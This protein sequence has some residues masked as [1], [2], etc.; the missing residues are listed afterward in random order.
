[1]D[2]KKIIDSIKKYGSD[3]RD[4]CLFG[5]GVPPEQ[6]NQH[7]IIAPWWEPSMLPLLGEAEY[8]SA[9]E[10]AEIKV[11]NIK[12]K[13]ED[14]TAEALASDI[15]FIKTGIGAPVLMD[16]ILAL[17]VT[18]CKSAI[19]VGAVGALDESMCIG[20]IVIPE[21]SLCGDGASRYI[22]SDSL[23]GG[24]IFGQAAY[25][26]EKLYAQLL[27]N[28]RIL[29]EENGVALHIGRTYSTDT[30][31]AEYAHI[32][33]IKDMGCN[34]I[35][36]ETAA[37]FRAARMAGFSLAAAFSISDNTFTN[38]TLY[39]K[40]PEEETAYRRFAR[41]T[42]F[43]QIIRRTLQGLKDTDL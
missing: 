38:Q 6:I 39:K 25:P 30:I 8:I 32:D 18:P 16:V 33:E 43:P 20:D 24:D 14:G 34:V 15:T 13:P 12:G 4:I 31:F 10:H 27:Q 29:C 35:E 17:G 28:A 2:Y 5:I 42:L 21:Y 22:A 26:D 3:D 9:S 11:W 40:I 23:K 37:A 1:V 41:N 7:V 19:F 36:M